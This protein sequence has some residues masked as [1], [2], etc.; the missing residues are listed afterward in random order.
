MGFSLIIIG[1]IFLI[2]ITKFDILPNF[3]GYLAIFIGLLKLKSLNLKFGLALIPILLLLL[4]N[5]PIFISNSL[6]LLNI[7]NNITKIF[8]NNYYQFFLITLGMRYSVIYLIFALF[9]YLGI[10]ELTNKYQFKSLI[11]Q[12]LFIMTFCILITS[13]PYIKV[14]PQYIYQIIILLINALEIII[15]LKFK[16]S[17]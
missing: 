9:F 2:P 16:Y 13:I 11:K 7:D 14:L 5:L 15:L 17:Q 6:F 10:K 4:Y 8:A 1:I 12:L 3:L